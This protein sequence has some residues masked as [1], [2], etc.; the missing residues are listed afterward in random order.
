MQFDPHQIGTRSSV[1][2]S[3]NFCKVYSKALYKT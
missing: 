3:R 1:R 2:N